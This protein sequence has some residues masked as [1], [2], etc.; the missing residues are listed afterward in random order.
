MK[1]LF[2]TLALTLLITLPILANREETPCGPLPSRQQIDLQ[3]ME[4]YAFIHFSINTYTGEEWGF[5]NEDPALFNP[6]KLDA[7]QWAKVIKDAGLTGIILTA[8]HHA[9]FCL[10]PSE[11]TEYSV[12]NSP[13]K[14]GKG[15]VVMQLKEACDKYGLKFAV[16]LSPW[17]RNYPE[18]GK[19]EYIDYFRNQL[20]EL[21]TNYGEIF[22][23]W[24]DG[25]NGGTGWYG[26][27]NERRKIDQS[28]YYDWGPTYNLIR[29]LQPNIVIWNSGGLRGDLRWVGTEEGFVGQPNWS[30][31]MAEGDVSRNQLHHGEE[32]G[33]KWVA[34]EVNT[35]IRPGWFYHEREDSQVKSLA[36][37]MDIYY[38]SVGRNATLLL[39]FPVRPDGLI[40]RNDS[41][42][43]VAFGKYIKELFKNDLSQDADIIN[44]GNVWTIKLDSVREFNRILLQEPIELGQRVK[45]FKLEAFDGSKWI[46]L[47]DELLPEEES[48]LTI[49]YKRIIC[50]PT[51]SSDEVRLTILDSKCEPLIS[52]ISIYLAPP[53]IEPLEHMETNDFV[54]VGKWRIIAPGVSELDWRK[55]IDRKDNSVYIIP[56]GS[57]IIDLRED[58]EFSGFSFL[59]D[60]R[61]REGLVLDYGLYGSADGKK[62]EMIAEGEF[63]NIENNPIRQT[64]EFTKRKVRYINFVPKRLC[65]GEKAA[66]ADFKLLRP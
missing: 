11:F 43:A 48:S 1:H 51:V 24:F 37:L 30:L 25:A 64:V 10:W 26:G 59:P 49:G 16:Y 13:W 5:G 56:E 44:E 39:N 36:T 19:P 60:K 46:E 29:G 63:S 47:N 3:K 41:I 33:D 21:L 55:A 6:E 66:I 14:D 12:K 52:N 17:D 22:E 34:A 23:V 45:S 50:F 65:E 32:N 53:I 58:T 35:S 8:K 38:K 40:D 31:L 27:A 4:A 9:G 42:T 57:L 61:T 7:E 15:D 62:W 54:D 28:A 2:L 18:Y 20:T